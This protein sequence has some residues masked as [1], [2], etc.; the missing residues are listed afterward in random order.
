MNAPKPRDNDKDDKRVF[1][2]G[3]LVVAILV[4]GAILLD[5]YWMKRPP[6][7]APDSPAAAGSMQKAPAPEKP[8]GS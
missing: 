6:A 7:T 5:V 2:W 8:P 3:I 4:I 1:R